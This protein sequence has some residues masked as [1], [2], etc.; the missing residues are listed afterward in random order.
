MRWQNNKRCSKKIGSRFL[1]WLEGVTVKV[2]ANKENVSE[3]TVRRRIDFCLN[4][5]PIIKI[6]NIK[7]SYLLI[8]ATYFKMG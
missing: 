1:L 2:V 4:N 5:P 7:E 6:P 3:K 8:D